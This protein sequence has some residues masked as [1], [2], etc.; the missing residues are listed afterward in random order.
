MRVV[1][2]N[3]RFITAL[4]LAVGV[5]S[6]VLIAGRLSYPDES[7]TWTQY[8][9]RLESRFALCTEGDTAP[10]HQRIRVESLEGFTS[11]EHVFVALGARI[12]EIPAEDFG[13]DIQATGLVLGCNNISIA[14]DESGG[15]Q[16]TVSYREEWRPTVERVE[17]VNLQSNEPATFR[18]Y[19]A[20]RNV[21][22]R[23]EQTEFAVVERDIYA[24]DLDVRTVLNATINGSDDTV[25][26]VVPGNYR[27]LVRVFD[28]LLWSPW[29]RDTFTCHVVAHSTVLHPGP[30][31]AEP[32]REPSLSV[33]AEIRSED[34]GFVSAVKR[35]INGVYLLY[36]KTRNYLGYQRHTLFEEGSE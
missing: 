26:I 19:A 13:K 29:Y 16:V 8:P 7:L 23:I 2:R 24:E 27:L 14:A 31:D 1:S 30:V 20:D 17:F 11:P 4:V 33:P 34:D 22:A 3:L 18:V 15:Y 21:D 35:E 25:T 36:H 10:T 9:Q 12:H 5:V 28:G 32:E 6:A